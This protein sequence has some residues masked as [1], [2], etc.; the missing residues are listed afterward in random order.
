MNIIDIIKNIDKSDSNKN[1]PD[2]DSICDEIENY[3]Y[4]YS[5]EFEKRVSEYFIAKWYCTDT[6]V[7]I[8]I[9]FLDDEPVCVLSQSARK[10][11]IRYKWISSESFNSVK[12]FID[13]LCEEDEPKYEILDTSLNIDDFYSVDFSSQLL[14]KEGYVN[15]CICKVTNTFSENYLSQQIEVKFLSDEEVKIVNVN[16]FKIPINVKQK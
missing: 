3:N 11:D 16:E 5:D 12:S 8:S 1:Y 14:V 9:L 13:S 2:F 4:P 6:Y 10:S 7:G 15:E